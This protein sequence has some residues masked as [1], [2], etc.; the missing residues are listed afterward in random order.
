MR[1]SVKR[2]KLALLGAILA[3]ITAVEY[4]AFTSAPAKAQGNSRITRHIMSSGPISLNQG[5]SALIGLLLPAVQRVETPGRLELVDSAGKVFLSVTVATGDGSVRT[6]FF[7]ATFADGSVRVFNSTGEEIGKSSSKDGI[8]IGLLLP[9]V[10][11]DG[12]VVAPIAASV[13][14]ISDGVRG[15]CIAFCDGSV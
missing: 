13:Q 6:A 15:Q 4:S 14:L 11:K 10:Q 9:A 5:E 3:A 1:D 2:I 8:L 7:H 12:A